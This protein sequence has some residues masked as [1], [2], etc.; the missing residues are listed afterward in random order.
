MN[1]VEIPLKITGI[2]AIK[3]ELRELKGAIADATDPETIAK[4][5]Q[6]AG[7]L[8]DKL[9]DANEAVNNFATGS[10][11]EQVSNSLGGIKDSLLSLDFEEAQQKA[12]VFASALGNVNPK[13]IS[14]GFKAFT[15]VIKTMGGAF[16]K[17]GIT[18]L[19][20]PIFLLVAAIVAIVAA[21]VMV[22]K[23]FGVLDAV[24]KALMAPINLI[25]DGF[26]ALTDMLGFTSF[27]AEENAE[28]VKK[29]EEAK[30]E[31]MNETFANRKKVAEMTAT[32]SREEIAMMEELTGVQ[33]DTSKS[34]FDIEEQ[35]LQ[36]N[37]ASLEAQLESLQAIEDAGGELT[38]EQIK[39]R[40]KLKDE[41]KKNNQAIEENER[42]RAKAIIEINQR[43][44]DL[45]IKSRMRL[46]AD[47][48]ERA[49]AQLKLDK[50]KEIKE[51]NILIRNA[52]VLGQSTKGFEEAKLNTIAFYANEATKIDTR[53]ADEAKKAAE[54]ERKENADR[55]KANYENY[56]KSLEQK[57]KATKDSNKVLILATEEGT[58]SRVDAE[59]KALQVEV[60]YMAKNAKAF[61]LSQDQLTII[62]A[63][64]LKQQEKLQEDYNKKVSDATNKENLAKAQND[65]LT[66]STDEAKL[67]A[68]IKLLE[69]EAKVKLQTEGLTAIEIKNINDQ[70][71][72][73]LG[74]VEKAK[75]DLAFEKTKKL[76]DA[77]KLRIETALSLAAFEL[78][79][80][81]GNKDEEIRLNNEFLAKQ[82]AVLD[83][84]KLAELNN[85]NLSETEK[86]AIREKFRQAKITAEE[87]T[88]KKIEEIEEAA[89]AKTLKNI[90]DG[91][92]TTKQALGAITNVQEIST[93]NK[94]KNVEKG[95]KQ[96][97]AIL[98]QQFEQ[99]KKM[100]L[101]M[102]AINGAQAIL[103][104]LSVP[105]FTLGIAS[106]IRIAA[107]IA[108]T[109]ASISAISSTSFEGGGNAP[110]PVSGNTTQS[111]IGQM[112]TPNLFGNNNN[113]NNVGNNGNS[114]D[115]S[116]PNFTV[117][118]VVS[119][120]EM[121]STQNRVNRIQRNA[122]L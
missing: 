6:R 35:R 81:K 23:Y 96:E 89:Q 82:L 60:D 65:L 77:E 114:N 72:V 90:N 15:G 49:K 67:D 27:A 103:A 54:K 95:S 30:R 107:S 59:V 75:T 37:Q 34:S 17:L 11:F 92:E 40:E 69:A 20:N 22:L 18:I 43:Q 87:A 19:A 53:V 91:F 101:A 42:A 2:G 61:K 105:D 13:E 41:Y 102:A 39:D 121:T 16:V 64:T 5:S 29:T 51:L 116:T 76:I 118:A 3:A 70:L 25:I 110:T 85:L 68:K 26:K 78:E 56:V 58:Q 115:Q 7:E 45:L 97:E 36:N 28:V 104:I 8:K 21:V 57:L 120:T 93:R 9:S 73:D 24:L 32:M 108:A 84:Q 94:L 66:A 44:N 113:A 100:N 112:A 111:N 1:E 86:E 38:E 88:A 12:K 74:V 14:A 109:A 80:F 31:A 106:G 119:E 71:A 83:A 79:R 50:E 55:Q 47:E 98:K 46:M 4:L 10:K 62:R 122:E 52:K 117:T 63:E 48:N 99:Q 33:I